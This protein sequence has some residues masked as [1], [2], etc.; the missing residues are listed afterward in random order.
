MYVCIYVYIY[1]YIQ[2][3]RERERYSRSEFGL[4]RISP[5]SERRERDPDPETIS[6]GKYNTHVKHI[7]PSSFF[8]SDLWVSWIVLTFLLVPACYR[9]RARVRFDFGRTSPPTLRACSYRPRVVGPRVSVTAFA[10]F[11]TVSFQNFK[12]VF[13]AWTLAI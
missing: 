1:I 6:F 5:R 11:T 13:A 8:F 7:V 2:R 4:V 3:E 10:T 12:F 9:S